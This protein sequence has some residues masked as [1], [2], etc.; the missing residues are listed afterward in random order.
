M[1]YINQYFTKK[2]KLYLWVFWEERYVLLD[3]F[4]EADVQQFV[5]R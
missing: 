2:Y 1:T 4:P 3:E 5:V